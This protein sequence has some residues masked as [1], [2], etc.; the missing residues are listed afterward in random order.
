M[1]T[2]SGLQTAPGRPLVGRREERTRLRQLLDGVDAGGAAVL[3]TGEPGIGKTTLVEEAA[4]HAVAAGYTVLR[5]VGVEHERTVGFG[6]LH[7]LLHPL[8]GH[9]PQLPRRQQATLATVF[10]TDDAEGQV[11]AP[12]RLLVH[13]ATLG[14]LEEASADRPLLLLVEDVQWLDRSSADLLGVLTRRATQTRVV[15]LATLRTGDTAPADRPGWQVEQLQLAPL[16]AE[17]SG[18]LLD[19]LG[20]PPTGRLRARVLEEA[21]GNPL[22]LRELAVLVQDPGAPADADRLP[23]LPL[24]QRLEDAFM[25]QVLRLPDPTQRFLL[26]AAAGE[27]APLG[28]VVAAARDLG[29]HPLDLAPAEA[30]GLVRVLAH[31][32]RFRHPLVRS[33]VYGAAPFAAR[34]AVHEALA[35]ST[36]AGRSTWHRAA[37]TPDPDEQVARAL[38]DVAEDAAQR[39]AQAEASAA[40]ERA[41]AL[42]VDPAAR[43]RRL[44]EAAETA[45]L[46]GLASAASLSAT[47]RP[48][49]A[50]PSAEPALA[51]RAAVTRWRL[52]ASH[53][54]WAGRIEELVR[55]AEDLA[56]P[57]G[58]AHPHARM[59]ALSAAAIGVNV[60]HPGG[61]LPGRVRD[62]LAAV[63][64][65]GVPDAELQVALLLV[66]PL[67]H[68]ARWRGRLGQ[69]GGAV[70]APNRLATAAEAIQ[71][72]PTA[73]ALWSTATELTRQA[74]EVSEEC[75]TLHGQALVRVVTGDLTGALASA[76]LTRRMSGDAGLFIVQAAALGVLAQASTWTGDL[77]RAAAALQQA[78]TTAGSAPVGRTAAELHW[79]AGLLALAEHRHRDAWV[80][81]RQVEEHPVVAAWAIGDLTEA[82]VRSGKAAEV[83]GVVEQLERD[84]A[85]F[86]S[87]HLA[88]LLH[89]S[90]A[91]LCDGP[92]AE[93]A[94][95][96]ATAAGEVGGAP[97]ELARTRLAH[98]VWLRRQRQIG[99]AV[100]PLTEALNAFD[101][102]GARLWA[103]RAAAEL[104]AAGAAPVDRHPR[105]ARDA[106]ALLTA[107]ELQIAHLAA[108]G[109][110]NKEI[111]DQVYLSHRTV[112]SHLYRIFPKLGLTSRAQLRDALG[113]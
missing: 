92:D 31:E 68:A 106:A 36:S 87:P 32:L 85:V 19:E 73:A 16:S 81:L 80:R 33:A 58:T 66:D 100:E 42:S 72:L 67:Q 8:T 1:S 11:R 4:D 101:A 83:T 86:G 110:T 84:N 97:L 18:Q 24:P 93:D 76:E 39:G 5:C 44:V 99:S 15:L 96:A 38:T 12:D 69:I 41:A 37:A 65:L 90:R 102:A 50:D 21:Y 9:L 105:G 29:L 47:V 10:G 107:Q 25:Q 74:R 48:L 26:V 108:D 113:R 98:G 54:E 30:A 112:G 56:G 77:E 52:S 20:T 49:L 55:L 6:G 95:R 57:T 13:A 53:G 60:L 7:Q 78:Q 62:A 45:R 3:V 35:G 71:D 34:L 22:A 64:P 79:A 94:Y 82:A 43:L 91:L 75:L 23:R 88:M 109:H 104:R 28:E 46:A 27:D 40:Y 2:T 111:A 17:E 63:R 61:T 14:L 89:R 70:P 59:R 103:E 51:V